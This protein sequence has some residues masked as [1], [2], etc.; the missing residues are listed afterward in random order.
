MDL[1]HNAKQM[2]ALSPVALGATGT[3]NGKIIDRKG[4][5]GVEF[6]V[7]YGAIS[8]T[9]SVVTALVQ[10]GDVTGSLTSVAD[11]DLNGT[12]AL[13]G[14]AAGARVSGTGQQVVKRI[15]YIGSKRYVRLS[16]TNSGT[17]SAGL[18]GAVAVM[19]NPALMPI[20]NP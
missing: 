10:E 4:Y 19:Y 8:T 17:T 3:S 15:G 18:M 16:L 5:G 13:V 12:E 11:L 14:L 2:L 1:H 20:S 7:T 9:G 6:Y